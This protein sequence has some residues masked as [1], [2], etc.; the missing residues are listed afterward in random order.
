[1]PRLQV[2]LLFFEVLFC[3][4]HNFYSCKIPEMIEEEIIVQSLKKLKI[5]NQRVQLF[6]LDI[7][8][9][10]H[11]DFKKRGGCG[12]V[13]RERYESHMSH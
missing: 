13:A 4:D 3:Q 12:V 8:F 10:Y 9:F 2:S 7:L 6:S 1:M 11:V 5:I